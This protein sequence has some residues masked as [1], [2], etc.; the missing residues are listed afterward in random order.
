MKEKEYVMPSVTIVQI[1]PTDMVCTSSDITSS[2]GA[3]YGGVD[4]EGTKT[5]DSRRRSVWDDEDE[6]LGSDD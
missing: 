1:A 6:D 3:D 2:L 5:V 4:E